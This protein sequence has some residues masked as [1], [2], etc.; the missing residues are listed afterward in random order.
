[1]SNNSELTKEEVEKIESAIKDKFWNVYGNNTARLSGICRQLAFAEGGICWFFLSNP[2]AG[3]SL[4]LKIILT[5]LVFFFIAD[6]GQYF[7]LAMNNKKLAMLYEAKLDKKLIYS[8]EEIIRPIWINSSGDICFGI[9]LL[10][11]GIASI[12]LIAKFYCR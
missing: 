2:S 10:F 4:D 7:M 1:M 5:F 6:A 3:I 12:L 11:L 8:K 9:K